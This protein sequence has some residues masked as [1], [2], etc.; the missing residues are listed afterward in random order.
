MRFCI[1]VLEDKVS[2]YYISA[3][4]LTVFYIG[5]ALDSQLIPFPSI[6]FLMFIL[7]LSSMYT[8]V[9]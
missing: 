5:L 4:S 2:Q 3:V 9:L 1:A 6:L 8:Y 7:I